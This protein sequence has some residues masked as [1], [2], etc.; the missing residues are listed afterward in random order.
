[1]PPVRLF[2]KVALPEQAACISATSSVACSARA[3]SAM[4]SG[5]GMILFCARSILS[6]VIAK[7]LAEIGSMLTLCGSPARL[8]DGL[9]RR[10][11]LHIGALGTLGR[12]LVR[13]SPVPVLVVHA[14]REPRPAADGLRSNKTT[15]GSNRAAKVA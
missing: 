1:M 14:E 4:V 3:P 9:S 6:G 5:T 12:Y 8:C 13:H 11:F 7:N 10:D 2:E 15:G